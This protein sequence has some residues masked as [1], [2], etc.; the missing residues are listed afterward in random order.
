MLADGLHCGHD[1]S[2]D[3]HGVGAMG[4]I[5]E[6]PETLDIVKDPFQYGRS[7]YTFIWTI[8]IFTMNIITIFCSSYTDSQKGGQR[9]GQPVKFERC[10]I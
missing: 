10:S 3:L 4:H 2:S 6:S 7:P 5:V 9:G 1:A 8:T